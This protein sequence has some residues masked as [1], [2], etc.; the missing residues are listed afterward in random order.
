MRTI[1]R[2]MASLAVA[3]VFASSLLPHPGRAE[4]AGAQA[5]LLY[6]VR[7]ILQRRCLDC[8]GDAAKGGIKIL[9]RAL[10]VDQRRVVRPSSPQT[11]EL[12]DLVAG[13][14][15]PP[16]DR[17]KLGAKEQD[18]LR[19]WIQAGAPDLPGDRDEAHVLWSIVR[20]HRDRPEEQKPFVRYLSLNHLA[21]RDRALFDR[22][23]Q[24]LRDMLRY[25]TA[26]GKQPSADVHAIE[27]TG[28]V[29]RIDLRELGWDRHPYPNEPLNLYDLILLEYPYGYLPLG[30]PFYPELRSLLLAAKQVRPISYVRADWLVRE[31]V[32][33]HLHSDFRHVLGKLPGS[34]PPALEGKLDLLG[35]DPKNGIPILPLDGLAYNPK[36]NADVDFRA[37]DF[38][39]SMDADPPAK[40]PFAPGDKMTLWIKTK[41][42]S[43][44]E[45]NR[46]DKDGGKQISDETY[47]TKDGE[48]LPYGPIPI[49]LM[50]KE[51]EESDDYTIYAYPRDALLATKTKFPNG[52]LLHAE[53]IRDRIIHPLYQLDEKNGLKPEDSGKM[54]KVTITVTTRRK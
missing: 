54:V 5:E 20:D 9:D 24:A 42:G 7:E 17:P 45:V 14:S 34:K 33:P 32:R 27:S 44:V 38:K 22:E 46:T 16:G 49:A 23:R 37:I 6:Q 4:E 3:I 29:F 43:V 30:S 8:H 11:S 26:E 28:T 48:V 1:Q 19:K 52:R 25:L 40:E 2:S 13:G 31:V 12:F 36:P 50:G 53:G 21:G 47:E 41:R 10:L 51:P 18:D 39:S 35:N 15:M